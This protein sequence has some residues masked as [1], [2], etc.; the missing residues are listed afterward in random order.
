MNKLFFP[1]L[2]SAVLFACEKDIPTPPESKNEG[3][4]ERPELSILKISPQIQT[5]EVC[6]EE[7]PNSIALS[8]T[9]TLILTFNLQALHGMSQYKIDIHNNFDCHAH[10]R[11]AKATGTPWQVL[12]VVDIEG[13]DITITKKLPVPENVQAGNYH[14]M[15]QALDLK[16]NEAEWV[17]Y[18]LK[19]QN[20]SDIQSP[21]IEITDPLTDSVSISNTENVNI[22]MNISD[23]EDLYGGRVDVTYH[24]SA[25]TEFTA[26]QYY[27]PEGVGSEIGYD[28]SFTFPLSPASGTYTFIIKAY[29]AVG[30]EAEK[31]L[32]VHIEE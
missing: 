29:D 15:L 24:N 30:N 4:P 12:D 18:S 9:D 27:F 16:G 7:D 17:L 19:V 3:L 22:E 32:K 25:G 2:L 5:L 20:G 13:Q 31:R 21:E 10:G 1:L 14:F 23:N 8:S 11:I 6:G 26:E 28:F